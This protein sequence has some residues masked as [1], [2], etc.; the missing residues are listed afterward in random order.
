MTTPTQ[1]QPLVHQF[2]RR[3][4]RRPTEEELAR[5]EARR[6]EGTA[7]VTLGLR[8]QLARLITKA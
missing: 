2:I 6:A 3:Y 7:V 4:G 5:F 8:R 1:D